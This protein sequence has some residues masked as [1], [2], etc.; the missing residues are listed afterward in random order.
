M[1]LRVAVTCLLG[2][3]AAG[4]ASP[5]AI[6]A[7]PPKTVTF[8]L[9]DAVHIYNFEFSLVH[10]GTHAATSL[11]DC[12]TETFHCLVGPT[13]LLAP[14]KCP[15]AK[16]ER[17]WRAGEALAEFLF[18]TKDGVDYFVSYVSEKGVTPHTRSGFAYHNERGII[19]TWYFHPGA[20]VPGNPSEF[21]H[22]VAATWHIEGASGLYPCQG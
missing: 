16:R 21:A 8:R 5:T 22:I 3:L 7:A 15:T 10:G 4:C 20:A 1:R 18:R 19:G 17:N 6:A 11:E 2:A 14:R 13:V 12:S 9:G